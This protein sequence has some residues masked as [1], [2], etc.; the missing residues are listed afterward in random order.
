MSNTVTTTERGWPGH[1]IA[2]A[3]CL[4]RRNTLVSCGDR[5]VVVSTVGAYRGGTGHGAVEQIGADRYYETMCFLGTIQSGYIDADVHADVSIGDYVPRGIYAER[6]CDLSSDSDASANIMHDANV[7]WVVKNFDEAHESG[8]RSR[9]D[10]DVRMN[11]AA[12]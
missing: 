5:H 6:A 3:G 4:F 1:F 9:Q 2:A 8:V 10:R 12:S 7:A 11:E